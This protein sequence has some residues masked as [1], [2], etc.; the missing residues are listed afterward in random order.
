M[1]GRIS[2]G[3]QILKQSWSVVCLDKELL[4]FP[5]ISGLA[6]LAV[7]ASFVLPVIFVPGL[8]QLFEQ[9]KDGQGADWQK[10]A[11]LA[12]SF[13]FY[14]VQYFVIVFFNTALVSCALIRFRGG[15]PTVGDGMRAAMSRLPQ[16]L[17]W[18]LLAATV[19][20]ILRMIE[21][22]V[23]WLGK[24]V[25]GLIG[26]AW[27]IVT[28]FIVPVLAAE[29]LGP[30]AAVKRSAALLRQTWGEALTG[31]VSMGLVSMLLMLPA[32]LVLGGGIAA[33]AAL[34]QFWPIIVGG[35]VFVVYL[36]ALSII[37]SAMQQIF[38]TGVY[39]YAAEGQ[40]AP[41]FS[42]ETLR[43]AFVAKKPAN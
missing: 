8:R 5:V 38:L 22:R 25:V 24:L 35:A 43:T 13:A 15:N 10:I 18:S 23:G 17:A 3:W 36:I 19:G 6:C 30:F 12:I 31:Q 34:Q 29:R 26:V 33:T 7:S 1:A 11:G 20:M 16:I 28:Y 9:V 2:R 32:F 14:F 21:E 27:S 4:L 39:L 41:G 40:V 42:E 37:T